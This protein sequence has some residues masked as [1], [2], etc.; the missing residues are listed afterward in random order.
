[1]Q[2]PAFISRQ[3]PILVDNIASFAS[4]LRKNAKEKTPILYQYLGPLVVRDTGLD[5][6][7]SPPLSGHTEA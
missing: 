4:Q 7:G 6:H 3:T 2:N 1:M 5:S